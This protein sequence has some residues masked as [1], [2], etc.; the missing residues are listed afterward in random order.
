ME[1]PRSPGTEAP[2]M[3]IAELCRVS[4]VRRSTVHHYLN[5]GLLPPPRTLGPRLHHFG[6]EHLARLREIRA[7]RAEGLG[8]RAIRARLDARP[9]PAAPALLRPSGA[10]EADDRRGRILDV[11]A[12]LFVDR[13]FDRVRVAAIAEAAGVGKATVYRLFTSKSALFVECLARLRWTLVPAEVRAQLTAD[14]PLDVEARLRASAVLGQRRAFATVHDLLRAAARTGGAD[15]AGRAQAALHRMITNVEP[16][17]RRA[18]DA[19][20]LRPIDGELQ[21]YML[22]GALLALGDR[23]DLDDRFGADEVL[24]A[25]LD[26]FGLRAAAT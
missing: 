1:T 8:L 16:S 19:G 6:P 22:W 2:A 18:I 12:R 24:E 26:L 7:L 5:L 23:L 3:K 15:V 21:A 25:F 14:L 20:A 11:A 4:G 17:L 13:G 9:R 10:G